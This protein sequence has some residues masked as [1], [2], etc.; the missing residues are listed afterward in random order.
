MIIQW[1]PGH[2]AKTKRQILESLKMIDVVIELLDAR[3][4]ESSRN[5]DMDTLF[6]NKPRVVLLNKY[7]LA[8]ESVTKQWIKYFQ[9][10]GIGAIG[11]DSMSGKNI[12][13]IYPIVREAVKEKFERLAKRGIIGQ[14]VRAMVAGIPNVGKS[15]FINRISSRAITATGDKPGVTRSKQWVKVNKE[16]EL[17]DTPGILWPKFDDEKVALHLAFTRA[18]KDEILDTEE[19]ALKFIQEMAQIKPS[20]LIERY[21]ITISE[22]PLENMMSIGKRRGCIISGGEI[23]TL[24]TATIIMD[25]YRSGRL[26]K[27]S[28]E[29]PGE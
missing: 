17:M 7:D 4:P 22:D 15:S 3:I 10:K 26:G 28:L 9:S 23:D 16:F 29:K 25:D 8:E 13:K 1:Y 12:S 19:L 6:Q 24:R 14:P 11:V 5:P 27:I 2:M 21:K 18:I 20:A